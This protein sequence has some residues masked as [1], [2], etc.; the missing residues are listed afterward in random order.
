MPQEIKKTVCC[1][2]RKMVKN[3]EGE[4]IPGTFI[5]EEKN[6]S[7]GYCPECAEKAM[8]EMGKFISQLSAKKG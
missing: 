7:H 5:E 1:D 2:C 3:E 4:W 8:E 6:L